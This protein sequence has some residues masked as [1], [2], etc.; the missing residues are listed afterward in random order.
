MNLI[1]SNEYNN[2]I[3]NIINNINLQRFFKNIGTVLYRK[4]FKK[5]CKH[6]FQSVFKI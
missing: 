4:V 2:N 6:I 3:Y 5:C 1:I